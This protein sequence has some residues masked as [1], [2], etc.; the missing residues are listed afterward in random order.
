M[1]TTTSQTIENSTYITHKITVLGNVYTVMIVSGK[2]NYIMVR[3]D[4]NNPFR[5]IMGREFKT[6]DD[7]QA[8]YKSKEM[9]LELLKIELGI[10]GTHV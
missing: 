1:A 2:Y 5:N 7:V 8:A 4:T 10:T 3:K 9:K 6:W